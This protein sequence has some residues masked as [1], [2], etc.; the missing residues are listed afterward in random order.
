MA[1]QFTLM[2]GPPRRRLALCT[3]WAKSSLPV[4]LSPMSRITESVGAARRASST[5]SA[6][7]RLLPT[8]SG[9]L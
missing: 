2:K 4:P 6:I 5:A 9:K 3:E 8:R 1:A 7:A